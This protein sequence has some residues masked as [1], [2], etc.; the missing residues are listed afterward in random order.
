MH[1]GAERHTVVQ[2]QGVPELEENVVFSEFRAPFRVPGTPKTDQN[3]VEHTSTYVL[4]SK[5]N[6]FPKIRFS[7]LQNL[8]FEQP[9]NDFSLF[10]SFR[11]PKKTRK[12]RFGVPP[13]ST[14]Q[15]YVLHFP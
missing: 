14:Q 6:N 13:K 15:I 11:T 8:D 12:A 2:K 10:S 7:I 9:S 3:D 5:K 1:F 4:L